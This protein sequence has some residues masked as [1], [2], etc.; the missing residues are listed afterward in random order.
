FSSSAKQRRQF[1]GLGAFVGTFALAIITW[2]SQQQ[3]LQDQLMRDAILK[4]TSPTMIQSLARRLE[5][6]VREANQAASSG[7]V[8]KAFKLYQ[9]LV[10][11]KGLEREIETSIDPTSFNSV[12]SEREY[13]QD[14]A[15][16]VEASLAKLIRAERLPKLRKEL[17][18]G[19]IGQFQVFEPAF[20]D[21]E[22]E[23]SNYS[24]LET[25]FTPGALRTTYTLLMHEEGANA[26][27][28]KDGL[29]IEG[30]ENLLPCELLED[31]EKLWRETTGNRCGW[32][33]KADYSQPSCIELDGQSLVF[34]LFSGMRS[35][36]PLIED[37]LSQQCQ[38]LNLAEQK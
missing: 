34:M 12:L 31:I 26:D 38:I 37:R 14:T 4:V 36:I 27:L 18:E 15:I 19:N 6:F 13:I 8:D 9:F 28:D 17:V 11:L 7:N 23:V 5:S 24:A 10:A 35:S 33:G 30:E 25:Q 2:N 22:I 29:L 1:L 21:S 20:D 32:F 3:A 16:A